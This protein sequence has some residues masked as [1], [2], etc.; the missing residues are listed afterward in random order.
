[1]GQ[2]E[3]NLALDSQADVKGSRFCFVWSPR[4]RGRG[5]GPRGGVA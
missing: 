3:V 2:Q 5:L 1:M 4:L